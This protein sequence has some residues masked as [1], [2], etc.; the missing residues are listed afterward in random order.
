MTEE[1]KTKTESQKA[2]RRELVAGLTDELKK[3]DALLQRAR[4]YVRGDNLQT[5]KTPDFELIKKRVAKR[6]QALRFAL[7][8]P[9]SKEEKRRNESRRRKDDLI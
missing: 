5:L 4:K 2:A 9:L 8:E 1:A 3:L 6:A 7:I